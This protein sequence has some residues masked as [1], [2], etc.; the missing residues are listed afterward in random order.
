M[1]Q[2]SFMEKWY[3]PR[4]DNREEVVPG[5]V[6]FDDTQCTGCRLCNKACPADSLVMENKTPRMKGIRENECMGC[7]DCVAICP[8]NAISLVSTNRYTGR[9]KTIDRRN[10]SPPRPHLPPEFM[11]K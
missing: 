4:Y 10:F 6:E 9:I 5:K 8:E 1:S 7:G 2:I 11:G 3:I